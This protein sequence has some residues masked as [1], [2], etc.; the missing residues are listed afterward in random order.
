MGVQA[1]A[2]GFAPAATR[3]A[4]ATG[5][6]SATRVG[7]ASRE[8]AG[9]RAPGADQPRRCFNSAENFKHCQARGVFFVQGGKG[10]LV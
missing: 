10:S 1:L 8:A 3:W 2:L 6:R 9:W 4:A 5:W 7:A